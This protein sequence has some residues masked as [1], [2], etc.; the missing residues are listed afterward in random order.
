MNLM[1]AQP[2]F[3]IQVSLLFGLL[4]I[5]AGCKTTPL[6]FHVTVP[7]QDFAYSFSQAPL[8]NPKIVQDLSA[9]ESDHGDQVV[10]INVLESQDSNR[11]FGDAQVRNFDGQNPQYPFVFSNVTNVENGETNIDEFGYRFVGQ[12]SSGVYVLETSDLGGGGSGVFENLLLVTFEYDKHLGCDWDKGEVFLGGNRL[13][14]KK[15]GEIVL[16]DRWDGRLAV[17]GNS[18]LVGRDKGPF[19][20]KTNDLVLKVFVDR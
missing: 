19:A 5:V 6:R 15:L 16:G 9:Y 18:I 20:Y 10:S 3:R 17:N 2:R 14:M 8:I 1:P 12:T 11:Y 13:L 4:L 7:N